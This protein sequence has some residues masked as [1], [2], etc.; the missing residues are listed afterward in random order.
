MSL[1]PRMLE[2]ITQ[3]QHQRLGD[4]DA[5]QEHDDFLSG[6][7]YG[8]SSGQLGLPG[9]DPSKICP[10]SPSLRKVS[11]GSMDVKSGG[12]I[13][14]KKKSVPSLVMTF[15]AVNK[16]KESHETAGHKDVVEEHLPGVLAKSLHPPHSPAQL[17]SVDSVMD[18]METASVA[19][20]RS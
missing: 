20:F 3:L 6:S 17:L 1:D 2:Q 11:V 19:S 18:R 10:S 5:V 12:G 15:N 9:E 4:Q 7:G 13:F 14:N 8:S 16:F